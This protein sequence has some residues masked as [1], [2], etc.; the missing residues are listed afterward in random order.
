MYNSTSYKE[1]CVK[2]YKHILLNRLHVIKTAFNNIYFY[3][4]TSTTPTSIDLVVLQEFIN[5]QTL[6][7]VDGINNENLKSFIKRDTILKLTTD[8]YWTDAYHKNL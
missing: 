5:D 8:D 4:S 2:A 1:N 3:T 7:Y 6:I